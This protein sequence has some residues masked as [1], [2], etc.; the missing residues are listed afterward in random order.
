MRASS[1]SGTSTVTPPAHVPVPVFFLGVVAPVFIRFSGIV[2]GAVKVPEATLY[3][4]HA[5][6]AQKLEGGMQVSG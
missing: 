1:S 3:G 6:S 4:A 2:E 5:A